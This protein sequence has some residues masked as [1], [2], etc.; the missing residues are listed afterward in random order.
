MELTKRSVEEVRQFNIQA[1]MENMD[2]L[3]LWQQRYHLP[4]SFL[5]YKH[6]SYD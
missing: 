2:D 6:A 4:E 1:Q 3:R 5:A